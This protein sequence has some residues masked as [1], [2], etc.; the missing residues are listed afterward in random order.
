MLL[1]VCTCQV[2]S[3]CGTSR[4][5]WVIGRMSAGPFGQVQVVVVE[6]VLRAGAA[7]EGAAS[8][9]RTGHRRP[10]VAEEGVG[11]STG[12]SVAEVDAHPGGVH[13][14]GYSERVGRPAQDV[15]AC[16]RP[17]NRSRAQHPF[18]QRIV[19]EEFRLPVESRVPTRGPEH[20]C[21]GPVVHPCV[22]ERP[23]AHPDAQQRDQSAAHPQPCD[24]P[25][26]EPGRPQQAMDLP[27]RCGEV[28]RPP[29]PPGLENCDAVTLLRQTQRRHA[30]AEP[31]ADDDH[32]A[33]A[34][35]THSCRHS[36][37]IDR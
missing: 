5:A 26:P 6:R 3:G 4:R 11:D 15:I 14:S 36:Q 2:P 29:A 23:A 24:A 35:P 1:S 25:A 31:G 37:Y 12:G 28:L 32:I 18:S 30:T 22:D 33:R 19:R 21:V 8:A 27:G 17:R 10:V 16:C 13:G 9:L 34:H 20:R 7:T